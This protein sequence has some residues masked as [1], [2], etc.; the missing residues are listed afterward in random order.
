MKVS[1]N[2]CVNVRKYKCVDKCKL[3]FLD[4]NDCFFRLVGG[5]I[6]L[7]IGWLWVREWVSEWASER[8][9]KG[10]RERETGTEGGRGGGREVGWYT[11]AKNAHF[12]NVMVSLG[13]VLTTQFDWFDVFLCLLCWLRFQWSINH[14]DLVRGPPLNIIKFHYI[15]LVRFHNEVLPGSDNSLSSRSHI[16]ILIVYQRCVDKCFTLQKCNYVSNLCSFRHVCNSNKSKVSNPPWKTRFVTYMDV[17]VNLEISSLIHSFVSYSSPKHND[18]LLTICHH[19]IF[20]MDC[21]RSS[22]RFVRIHMC[23]LWFL[24]RYLTFKIIS[25]NPTSREFILLIQM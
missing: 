14:F 10:G 8:V 11:G 16:R 3:S 25:E 21:I 1:F 2:T 17:S 24:K 23:L 18:I 4:G 19:P 6:D 9:R 15:M 13:R 5:W 20:N 12:I 22:I 7:L